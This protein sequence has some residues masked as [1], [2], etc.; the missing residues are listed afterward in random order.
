MKDIYKLVVGIV[1]ECFVIYFAIISA[2]QNILY[3]IFFSIY[4]LFNL[5]FTISRIHQMI[6]KSKDS[7]N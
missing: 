3:S 2:R 6:K 1:I 5:A 4:A 7:E